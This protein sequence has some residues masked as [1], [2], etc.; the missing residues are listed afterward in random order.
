MSRLAAVLVVAAAAAALPACSH[1]QTLRARHAGDLAPVHRQGAVELELVDGRRLR[2]VLVGGSGPT[3]LFQVQT[4]MIPRQI[5]LSEVREVSSRNRRRGAFE[6]GIIG[7]VG[8]AALGVFIG[9]VGGEK[10]SN[11]SWDCTPASRATAYGVAGALI[12]SA[13]GLG[14]GYA[15]GSRE[16]Y[17]LEPAPAGSN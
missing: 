14:I 2:G 3:L 17:V 10:E 12:G 16:S 8:A 15:A 4:E 5:A 1:D 11:C 6:G 7:A 13:A 9:V